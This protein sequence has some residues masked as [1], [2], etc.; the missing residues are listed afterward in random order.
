MDDATLVTV[1]GR[2]PEHQHGVVNPPVYHASTIIFPT[3]VAM[4]SSRP[5][6]G[7]TYGRYGTPTTFAL[8]EAV[9]KLEGGHRAIAVGSGKTAITST[10]L[11]LLQAGDHLLVTDTV[12]APTRNFCIGTPGTAHAVAV[13]QVSGRIGISRLS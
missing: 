4:E 5:H 6:H 10:L 11:A 2:D 3:V 1:A 7:V 13:L 8:E 9:A 12:Y